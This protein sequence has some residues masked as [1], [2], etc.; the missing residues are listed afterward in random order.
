MNISELIAQSLLARQEQKSKEYTQT[1]WHA[2]S[3]GSCQR[4]NYLKRLGLPP[5][6]ELDER[7]LRKFD[8]GNIMEDWLVDLIE[9]NV[10]VKVERQKRV[11]SKK[12]DL[13]GKADAVLTYS[14]KG[15][16]VL[17]IKSQHSRSFWWMIKN[18]NKPSRHHEYQLWVYLKLMD[19]EIGRIVYLSKD[20][21]A[22]QEYI[23]RRDDKNLEREVVAE[24]VALNNAWK[25]KDP[26]ILAL[27]EKKSWQEKFCSVHKHCV[28]EKF[29]TSIIG[30][31]K[32]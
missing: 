10:D 9:N 7:T 27:P 23:V 6:E 13:S 8:V 19:I 30:K 11:Q 31:D 18:G 21:L 12:W 25:K 29:L 28:D 3:L 4:G 17:E 24:L 2:S 20:D 5:D 1:S 26:T 14:S 16:E 15:Q 32:I 22:I